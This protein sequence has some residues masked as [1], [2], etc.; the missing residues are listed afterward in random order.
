MG[1]IC[2]TLKTRPPFLIFLFSCA[3]AKI[4]GPIVFYVYGLKSVANIANRAG[5][6]GRFS[7]AT[8]MS[9]SVGCHKRDC[10]AALLQLKFTKCDR[11]SGKS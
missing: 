4:Q 6:K 7:H 11:G 1:N 2:V 5:V 10:R 3:S 8:L 9:A